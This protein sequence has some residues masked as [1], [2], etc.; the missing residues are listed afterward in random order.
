MAETKLCK[1]RGV[2]KGCG[3]IKPVSEFRPNRTGS[4]PG[5]CKSCVREQFYAA[6]IKRGYSYASEKARNP[7]GV[8]RWRRSGYVGRRSTFRGWLTTNLTTRRQ[9]CRKAGVDFTL[10]VDDVVTLYDEQQG[11]CALTG[12][13]LKW[14]V[15]TDRGPDTLSM[16]RIEATGAY[17]PGNVRLVTHWANVAR[18]RFTDEEFVEACRTV[19]R[20]ALRRLSLR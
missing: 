15:D 1:G 12:R 5:L 10:T 7:D 6:R 20:H 18:H 4:L 9:Q 8:K 16:D 11:F 14:G 2:D 19:V 3:Q 17:V 13:E